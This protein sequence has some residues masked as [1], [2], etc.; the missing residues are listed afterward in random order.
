[1]SHSILFLGNLALF[2]LC[3]A[4][5]AF[6]I[7]RQNP[8]L[9]HFHIPAPNTAYLRMVQGSKKHDAMTSKVEVRF[10]IL[11]P[12]VANV[13]VTCC[14]PTLSYLW[15]TH[16]VITVWFPGAPMTPFPILLNPVLP[17]AVVNMLGLAWQRK[18]NHHP[19]SGLFHKVKEGN[20]AS[21]VGTLLIL[22]IRTVHNRK[23]QLAKL[24]IILS[25]SCLVSRLIICIINL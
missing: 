10:S 22:Q 17:I 25:C 23:E 13:W 4:I 18:S 21:W 7:R 15:Q 11:R 16:S 5:C 9:I 12:E 20:L 19:S 14:Q 24:S 8:C 1:M 3:I 6:L 2:N